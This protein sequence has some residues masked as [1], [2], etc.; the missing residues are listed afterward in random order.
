MNLNNNRIIR[1]A[2][3][4]DSQDAVTKL[5]VDTLQ[6]TYDV[7]RVYISNKNR[8]VQITHSV[9]KNLC[10]LDGHIIRLSDVSEVIWVNISGFVSSSAGA[11]SV[12]F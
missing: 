10:T 4:I 5:N 12:K 6:P 9:G 8:T 7:Y 11:M 2:N 3:P 1:I